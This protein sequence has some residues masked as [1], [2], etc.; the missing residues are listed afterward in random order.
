MGYLHI[1]NLYKDQTVLKF[2]ECYAL[3]KIHG[4]SAHIAWA[5]GNLR[6]FSGGEKHENFVKLFNAEA[7]IAKFRNCFPAKQVVIY[8]EAYGG[9]CQKMSAVYGPELRFVAFD[10]QVDGSWMTVPEAYAIVR[11]SGLEFVHYVQG[12]TTLAF[13]DGQRDADSEQAIRNGMG[14]SHLREGIVIRPLA[15]LTDERGNRV[16]AKHKRD[17]FRETASPRVVTEVPLVIVEAE[18]AANEWVTPMRLEHVLD[19]MQNHSIEQMRDILTAMVDDVLREGAGEVIDSP[20]L[21]K[22]ISKRTAVMYKYRLKLGLKA[23]A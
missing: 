1:N 15:E 14:P 21:R 3:E 13:L 5:N 9:K 18:K 8:G 10:V 6:F 16:I 19:K 11:N 4:T 7:L 12:P 20:A 2:P 22:A 17:E 23:A